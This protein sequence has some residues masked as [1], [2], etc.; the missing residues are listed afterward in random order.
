MKVFN[1]EKIKP[2]KEEKYRFLITSKDAT[3]ENSIGIASFYENNYLA[4]PNGKLKI[5]NENINGSLTFRVQSNIK[6]SLIKKR[7]YIIMSIAIMLLEIFIFYP[8]L[9]LKDT[10]SDEI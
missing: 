7:Y 1:F 5:N 4:Y 9:R 2:K 6:R 8:Y 10:Q 3:E